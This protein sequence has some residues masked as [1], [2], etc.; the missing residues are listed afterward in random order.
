[1]TITR[2]A[3]VVQTAAKLTIATLL[4]D[5]D[6]GGQVIAIAQTWTFWGNCNTLFNRFTLRIGFTLVAFTAL[7]TFVISR[8]L[9]DLTIL[10]R[11]YLSTRTGRWLRKRKVCP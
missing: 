6:I 5:T 3:L 9:N 10:R 1:A 2:L 8:L 7:M 11:L 4:V